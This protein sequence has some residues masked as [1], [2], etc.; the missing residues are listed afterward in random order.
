[1]WQNLGEDLWE[2]HCCHAECE[3]SLGWPTEEKIC[4]FFL[5][6]REVTLFISGAFVMLASWWKAHLSDLFLLLSLARE[7]LIIWDRVLFLWDVSGACTKLPELQSL[8]GHFYHGHGQLG[9]SVTYRSLTGFT[10][11][12]WVPGRS[13]GPGGPQLQSSHACSWSIVRIQNPT[14]SPR[15]HQTAAPSRNLR[16]S[17]MAHHLSLRQTSRVFALPAL[18][19]NATISPCVTQ[20][21]GCGWAKWH[22]CELGL[23]R[24]SPAPSLCVTSRSFCSWRC[25]YN[26]IIFFPSEICICFIT[27]TNILLGKKKKK[28]SVLPVKT[29]LPNR[30]WFSQM[31]QHLQ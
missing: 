28:G 1:M 22:V 5:Y 25:L 10:E 15:C 6:W 19:C 16:P 29:C 21:R 18:C 31:H 7:R 27:K 26:T 14:I 20:L 4:L 24:G 12:K 13:H 11:D 23:F 30:G 3:R 8:H 17:S 9:C 2:T